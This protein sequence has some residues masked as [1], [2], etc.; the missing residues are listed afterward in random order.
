MSLE[1]PILGMNVLKTGLGIAAGIVVGTVTL[2]AIRE[3]RRTPRD[4]AEAAAGEALNEARTATE[5]A[6]AAVGHARVAGE[7]A[8][9][10]ARDEYRP[11]RPS[12]RRTEQ[13]Q[14]KILRKVSTGRNRR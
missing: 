2:R 3:R 7:K 5:H 4:E 13:E 12:Q 1:P 14:P 11:P 6:A 9:E 10:H 8:V